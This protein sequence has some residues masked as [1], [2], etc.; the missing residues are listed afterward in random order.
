MNKKKTT[1]NSILTILLIV[2][3][4]SFVFV[5]LANENEDTRKL[6]NK[7]ESSEVSTATTTQ[8][9]SKDWEKVADSE[10][11]SQINT[12]RGKLAMDLVQQRLD[13]IM[14]AQKKLI[15]NKKARKKE[16]KKNPSESWTYEF[17][18]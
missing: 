10:A 1:K 11:N 12:R 9:Q 14:A 7:K 18:L 6:T 13:R 4:V 17:R 2:S 3:V 15:D 8:K 5:A 16:E